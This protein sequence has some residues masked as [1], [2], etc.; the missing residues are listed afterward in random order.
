MKMRFVVCLLLVGTS[1]VAEAVSDANVD[2]GR[3]PDF[4]IYVT[5]NGLGRLKP[6]GCSGGQLGGFDRRPAVL[7]RVPAERRLLIDTGDLIE[8]ISEQDLIKFNVT[9]RAYYMLGYDLVN[10]R[11][12]D[13]EAAE[14]LGLK[15]DMSALFS[16]ISGRAESGLPSVFRKQV[17]VGSE[18]VNLTIAALSSEAGNIEDALAQLFDGQGFGEDGGHTLSILLTEASPEEAQAIT[19]L[20]MADCIFVSSASDE[21]MLLSKAGEQP[22]VVTAGRLGKYIGRLDVVCGGSDELE[23][24]YTSIPLTEDIEPDP[25]LVDLYKGYQEMVDDAS[26]L[27][28]YPKLA[29]PDEFEYTGSKA[30]QICHAYE[31]GKWSEKKHAAAFQTLVEVG[32]DKDPECV[33]CHVVGMEY[34]TGYVSEKKTPHLKNVGC[35]NCHGPGSEHVTTLGA[36]ETDGPIMVCVDCHTP[37]HSAEYAE[38]ADW[39]FEQIIHWKEPLSRTRVEPGAGSDK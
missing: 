36:T 16:V 34:E 20:G 18:Q 12:T 8:N 29:L 25:A 6:C 19:D 3:T 17:S 22:L 37:E 38:K 30:C 24:T 32:S 2:G 11:E 26:L 4:S 13:L 33:V 7:S 14:M 23:L 5:G 1:A 39:Y 15:A 9:V 27:E 31:Y 28:E 21:P 35:E 10:L